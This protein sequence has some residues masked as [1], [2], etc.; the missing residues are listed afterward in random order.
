MYVNMY[1]QI[2]IVGQENSQKHTHEVHEHINV[3]TTYM[4]TCK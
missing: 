2:S 3:C 4:N 1:L